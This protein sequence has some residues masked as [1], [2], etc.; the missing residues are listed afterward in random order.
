MVS[1]TQIEE[2]VDNHVRRASDTVKKSDFLGRICRTLIHR[3]KLHRQP[4]AYLKIKN[5]NG[6]TYFRCIFSEVFK[7]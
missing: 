2:V 4:A 3:R 5:L 1:K 7:I 6:G